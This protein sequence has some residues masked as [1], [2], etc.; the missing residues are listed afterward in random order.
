L[1]EKHRALGQLAASTAGAYNTEGI[2]GGV[3]LKV[4]VGKYLDN[5]YAILNSISYDIPDD[6]SWDIDEKLAMYLKVSINLTIIH[7]KKLPQYTDPKSD[8][9][10]GFF[11][12]LN[13]SIEGYLPSDYKLQYSNGGRAN[14]STNRFN[15]IINQ[16]FIPGLSPNNRAATT[17]LQQSLNQGANRT[18]QLTN[19]LLSN[20]RVSPAAVTNL[21]KYNQQKSN[22]LLLKSKWGG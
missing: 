10:S 8:T 13:N 19:Q 20:Q 14:L 16:Q 2:M 15:N 4:E 5:E 11:G 17:P 6:S 1:F 9:T 12:Y 22:E 18:S 3:L 7:S 21:Q